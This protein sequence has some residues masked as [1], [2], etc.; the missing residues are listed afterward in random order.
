MARKKDYFT[1]PRGRAEYPHL[2]EPDT[3]FDADGKYKVNLIVSGPEAQAFKE[4]IDKR[5]EKNL[6]RIEEQGKDPGNTHLPYEELEDGSFRFKFKSNAKG[7]TREGKTFSRTIPLFDA[8]GNPVTDLDGVGGGS[9]I[10]VAGEFGLWGPFG[11]TG[12]GVTLRINAVQIIE[13]NEYEASA[14]T[15]G[16]EAEDG[17]TADEVEADDGAEAEGEDLDDGEA[18]PDAEDFDF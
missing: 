16:F 7:E 8:A 9:I 10:R 2:V 11:A 17:F 18:E 6:Q 13:L 4:A 5:M 3:K 15:Y 14:E 12:S 1:S